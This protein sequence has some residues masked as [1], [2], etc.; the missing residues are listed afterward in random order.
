MT[1]SLEPSLSLESATSI[2]THRCRNA[3]RHTKHEQ[4]EVHVA[5]ARASG[6]FRVVVGPQQRVPLEVGI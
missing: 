5:L 2:R 4:G 6:R 1:V 3:K